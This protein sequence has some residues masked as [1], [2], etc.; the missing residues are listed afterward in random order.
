MTTLRLLLTLI[1]EKIEER[2][3]D[4]LFADWRAARLARRGE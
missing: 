2:H 4:R 1:L 3:N